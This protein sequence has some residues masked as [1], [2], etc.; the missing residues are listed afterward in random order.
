MLKLNNIFYCSTF[1]VNKKCFEV[2]IY[3]NKN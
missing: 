3:E 1:F 2:N